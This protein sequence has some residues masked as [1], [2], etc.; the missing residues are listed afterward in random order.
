MT[1]QQI[2]FKSGKEKKEMSEEY[3]DFK[4]W[5]KALERE[6]EKI[7]EERKVVV[8]VEEDEEDVEEEEEE[9]K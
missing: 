4:E 7:E 9:K 1:Q 6:L 2:R 3:Y 5:E 8:V